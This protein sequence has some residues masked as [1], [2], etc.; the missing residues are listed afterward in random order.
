MTLAL[1]LA[2]P[3]VLHRLDLLMQTLAIERMR[4]LLQSTGE[5]LIV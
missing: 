4:L 2:L 5:H 1:P 3:L